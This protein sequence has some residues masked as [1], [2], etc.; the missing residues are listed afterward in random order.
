MQSRKNA[1]RRSI[2]VDLKNECDLINLLKVISIR[3]SYCT[4]LYS[5]YGD[6]KKPILEINMII[7]INQGI[8]TP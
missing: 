7:L 4:I 8:N 2:K 6:D 3:L 5:K 1:E